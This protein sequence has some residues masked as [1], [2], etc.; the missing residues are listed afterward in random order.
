MGFGVRTA[1][2]ATTAML[3]LPATLGAEELQYGV[4]AGVA[5]SSNVYGVSEDEQVAGGEEDPVSDF[6]TRL[7]PYF[8]VNDPDGDLTWTLNYQPTYEGYLNESDLDGFDHDVAGSATWRFADRWTLTLREGYAIYQ[9]SIR[10]NETVGPGEEASLGFRNQEIRANRTGATLRHALSPRDSFGLSV[11]YNAFQYPDGG[12][13]DRA[14]PS[15]SFDYQ[16]TLSERTSLGTRLSWTQQTYDRGAGSDD[17]T[18]F[19]NLAATFT[20]RFSPTFRLEGSAGPTFVDSSPGTEFAPL[21]YAITFRELTAPGGQRIRLP[22]AIDADTCAEDPHPDIGRV[23]NLSF[24]APCSVLGDDSN[25]F[26]S[27]EEVQTLSQLTAEVPTIDEQGRLIDT[28]DA[29]GTDLTYFAHLSL[30]K[31]WESWNANLS[32]DRSNSENARFG[33]SSVADTLSANLSWRPLRLWTL[34][35]TAAVSLQE[36]VA[37]QVVPIGFEVANAPAP[38]VTFAGCG[39]D[40][41]PLCE[42][43]QVQRL[44]ASSTGDSE[45]YRTQSLSFNVNRQLS[46]RS[47]VFASLYWY[48]AEQSGDL[49][50]ETERWNHFVVWVGLEWKFDPVRF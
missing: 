22:F 46:Q 35:L 39:G 34:G 24:G 10:F 29:S 30:V 38:G 17:Q 20:H 3:P 5:W 23:A 2:L 25:Q 11:G 36:Q 32:Y 6:S 8:M 27:Q 44:V 47:F 48:S 7:T 21:E 9:N 15:A 28:G 12:G 19:Y 4:R 42:I 18:Q 49:T 45:E 50:D 26:L 41:Q 16:H 37:D 1:L 31:D 40:G 33:S 43:A 13:N 14:V